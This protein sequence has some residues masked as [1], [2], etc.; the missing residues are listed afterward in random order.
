MRAAPPDRRSR[1]PANRRRC[2]CL[3][4]VPAKARTA[5]PTRRVRGLDHLAGGVIDFGYREAQLGSYRVPGGLWFIYAKRGHRHSPE[6]GTV[7]AWIASNGPWTNV[8][9]MT[10]CEPAYVAR[11]PARASLWGGEACAFPSVETDALVEV[12]IASFA[13]D[14]YA[15]MQGPQ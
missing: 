10:S 3:S 1:C 13:W 5:A 7:E 6:P 4:C 11:F 2:P 8:V 15:D 9:M 14:C 12:G